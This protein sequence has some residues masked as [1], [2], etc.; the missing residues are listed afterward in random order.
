MSDA[1]VH[2][3]LLHFVNAD[4]PADAFGLKTDAAE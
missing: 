4:A 2:T 1:S 3:M